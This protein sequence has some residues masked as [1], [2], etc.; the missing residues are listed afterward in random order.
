M[1][2]GTTQLLYISSASANLIHITS[3][4]ILGNQCFFSFY[5]FPF[6]FFFSPPASCN[7]RLCNYYATLTKT[8][9]IPDG[10][11]FTHRSPWR[12]EKQTAESHQMFVWLMWWVS[13]RHRPSVFQAARWRRWNYV[14][15]WWLSGMMKEE[16]RLV[17][18]FLQ[19]RVSVVWSCCFF[20]FIARI[21]Y[22]SYF[23]LYFLGSA[24]LLTSVGNIALVVC[25]SFEPWPKAS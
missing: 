3:K 2:C 9:C 12:I 7:A 10:G 4:Q 17:W 14:D 16:C 24:T 8:Q 20:I 13:R 1:Q 25:S 6:F 22:F 5:S 11:L 19:L 15:P 18:S 21:S 23:F